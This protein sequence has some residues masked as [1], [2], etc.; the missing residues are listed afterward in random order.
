MLKDRSLVE[1]V[2]ETPLWANGRRAFKTATSFYAAVML[3]YLATVPVITDEVLTVVLPHVVA[4]LKARQSLE[5][6]VLVTDGPT[7][8]EPSLKAT[9]RKGLFT[10]LFYTRPLLLDCYLHDPRTN[11]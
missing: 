6:Q 9:E 5:L 7:I 3:Q 1:F 4:G 11:L 2:C 8:I 10:N